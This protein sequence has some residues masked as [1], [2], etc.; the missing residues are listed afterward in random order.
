M[1]VLGY[2]G[3]VCCLPQPK[4][5]AHGLYLSL[6]HISTIIGGVALTIATGGTALAVVGPV[7]LAA[8]PKAAFAVADIAEG[9]DGYSKVNALDASK[10]SNFIRDN[11]MGGNQAL[12]DKFSMA[13]DILFDVVSGKAIKNGAKGLP[14]VLCSGS[15]TSNMACLLYTSI[16]CCRLCICKD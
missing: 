13:A 3:R 1:G 6:I 7:L 5:C 8:A 12:Y 9:L 14:K 11:L 4:L 2:D 15:A 16:I 10:P